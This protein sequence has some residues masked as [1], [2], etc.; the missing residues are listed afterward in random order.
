MSMKYDIIPEP[1]KLLLERFIVEEQT[2][3]KTPVIW[4]GEYANTKTEQD[5]FKVLRGSYSLGSI[6]VVSIYQPIGNFY[7]KELFI[8]NEKDVLARLELKE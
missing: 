3:E 7:G 1:G 6:V 8:A 2:E 5:V 4:L